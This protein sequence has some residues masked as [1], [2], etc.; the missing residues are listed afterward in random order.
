MSQEVLEAQQWLNSTYG[1]DSRYISV[2]ET[3]YPGSATSEA[4]VSALQIDLGLSNV[5]GYFGESTVSACDESPLSLGSTDTATD[6]RVKILQYGFY[7]KG[8]YAYDTDGVFTTN[9]QNALISIQEDAGLQGTQISNVAKGLQMKAVLGVDEYKLVSR[10]DAR[11]REMQ[12]EL[13]RAYLSY[14]GLCPCD[15]IYSRGTNKA[16]IYALQAEEN[17]PA[18]D[19]TGYFGSSTKACC[20]DIPYTQGQ[21]DYSGNAYDADNISRFIKLAQYALY[22]IGHDR[23]TLPSD[24]KYNPGTFNGEFNSATKQ[25]LNTFQ[26]DVCLTVR[27]QIK[28]D[29]WMSL[30]VSTGNPDRHGTAID[31]ATRLTRETAQELSTKGYTTVGRYLTGDIVVNNT[32]IAK[33]LLRP[34]MKVIFDAG[35]SLFVIFQD[36]RQ[37]YRENPDEENIVNYFTEERGYADAEKAFSVAKSLGVPMNEIIYFAVDYDFMESQVNARVIPYFKGINDYFNSVTSIFTFRVGIYG[38]RNTCTLVKNQGYSVS[39]FVSDLSTGYSGNMGFALPDDWAFDQVKEF[40]PGEVVSIGIDKDIPSGRYTGFTDFLE[41]DEWD[42]MSHSGSAKVFHRPSDV[43]E[44]I[45]QE[46]PLYWAKVKD[47]NGN[48]VA[49]Y[50]MYDSIPAEAFFTI[51]KR[52]NQRDDAEDDNIRYVYF[53]DVG[54]SLNAGYIDCTIQGEGSA[55]DYHYGFSAFQNCQVFRGGEYGDGGINVVTYDEYQEITFILTQPL[56]SFNS[57][58]QPLN[59]N[60]EVIS[61]GQTLAPLP[62]GTLVKIP[63]NT[64]AGGYFPNLIQA[65]S[66]MLPGSG[67][68][69]YID[70]LNDTTGFLDLGFEYGVLPSD[71]ALINGYV[72]EYPEKESTYFFKCVGTNVDGVILGLNVYAATPSQVKNNT[73]VCLWKHDKSDD[74]QKWK[75]KDGGSEIQYR[76]QAA[77]GT[78]NYYLDRLSDE[79]VSTVNNAQ[80]YTASEDS[81]VDFE[82]V[83]GYINRLKITCT[84]GN[85]TSGWTKY[86]LTAVSNNQGSGTG[87]LPTSPGNVYWLAGDAPY[88]VWEFEKADTE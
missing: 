51:K 76:L 13:N 39:S 16:L 62:V 58:G 4:L 43:Y 85:W 50:P 79:S 23:Y 56:Q 48:F 9:T 2:N 36:S 37:Y 33:N 82:P 47:E 26:E 41:Y 27:D 71:R 49:K 46:F 15:G 55:N 21:V 77:A 45:P 31:C 88:Q 11:I 69:K 59:S 70:E 80:T 73:N 53:R 81:I 61:A 32:R 12:Q 14:T 5:T 28:L 22:C 67:E 54:G 29:E 24:S 66:K 42:L 74:L 64:F 78:V 25:A 8:Y 6:R 52:N 44:G 38:S 10:G 3:G 30:L 19:S 1:D 40:A 86:Y 20:P 75:V 65:V 34:E 84:T 18:G 63:S 60:G 68:W 35:L 72:W 7:C 87:K 17:I 83:P 57:N